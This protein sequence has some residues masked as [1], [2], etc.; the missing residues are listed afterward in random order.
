[1]RPGR[2]R[3]IGAESPV[4]PPGRPDAPGMGDE[5]SCT[6]ILKNLKLALEQLCGL[7]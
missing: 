5:K 6:F 7:W 2:L 4:R 1:M 3:G